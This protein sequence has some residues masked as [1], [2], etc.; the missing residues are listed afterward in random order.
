MINRIFTIGF[1]L[2]LIL[3][4]LLLRSFSG[5]DTSSFIGPTI[6]A[7]G[8]SILIS[9]TEIK[10]YKNEDKLKQTVKDEIKKYGLSLINKKELIFER[11]LWFLVL[12]GLIVWYSSC[13]IAIKYPNLKIIGMPS[14]LV[15][16][17][18]NYLLGVSLLMFKK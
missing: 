9:L 2:Y 14:H 7:A 15:V 10:E 5:T 18:I 13:S 11:V 16:G 17:S 4:E 3:F 1:P 6:A 12:V 8:L